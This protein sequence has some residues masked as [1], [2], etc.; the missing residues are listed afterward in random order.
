MAQGILEML[1]NKKNIQSILPDSAGT[2]AVS[3]EPPTENA[4]AISK[5]RGVDISKL[6]SK[7]L[8]ENLVHEADLI[9]TMGKM[10]RAI[11]LN[12]VPSAAGNTFLL[13]TFGGKAMDPESDQEIEDPISG[14][15]E[16]YV[17][18]FENIE[19][20]IR[21]IFPLIRGTAESKTTS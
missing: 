8:T 2:H 19:R 16:A 4:I 20:E 10:H 21:R 5:E 9:L 1:L 11:I 6:L 13:K 18:C 17:R 12:A 7:P 15:W 3:G 14:K